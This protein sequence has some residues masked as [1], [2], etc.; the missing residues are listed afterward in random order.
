MQACEPAVDAADVSVSNSSGEERQVSLFAAP[1]PSNSKDSNP[2]DSELIAAWLPEIMLQNWESFPARST[3]FGMLL[4]EALHVVVRSRNFQR[5][6]AAELERRK[7]DTAYHLA[8]GLSHELNNPLANISTRAGILLQQ[9][10]HSP[11]QREMLQ[12]IVE[13]AMRGSEMLADLMLVARPPELEIQTIDA[14]AFLDEFVQDASP[15]AKRWGLEL[16]ANYRLQ[17]AI[18]AD[19]PAL[20]EALWALVRNAIEASAAVAEKLQFTAQ[21]GLEP[22]WLQ[23][24]ITDFGPGLSP[25][26]L[27]HCFDPYYSGREAGRG[28]GVGLT[29]ALRII[30]LHGGLLSLKNRSAEGCVAMVKIPVSSQNSH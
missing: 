27:Q 13:N 22:G 8:Y 15:W 28:L 18:Q 14:A 29:K 26:A 19:P 1:S 5:N 7:Q 3:E 21:S 2:L 9:D 25:Q 20:R 4:Q 30:Q 16:V 17:V 10:T 12:T 11:T 6:N 24:E 23:I